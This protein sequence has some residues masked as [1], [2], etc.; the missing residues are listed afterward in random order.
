MPSSSLNHP[1][2][3]KPFLT[4]LIGLST[5]SPNFTLCSSTALPP[6]ELNVIWYVW[7]ATSSD[8]HLAYSVTSLESSCSKSEATVNGL[9][10][11]L[12]SQYQPANTWSSFS[13]SSG[14][15]IDVTPN[16]ILSSSVPPL[17]SK[18]IVMFVSSTHEA[19]RLITKTKNIN[20]AIF[21]FI[22][23]TPILLLQNL[24][25]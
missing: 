19:N 12:L 24:Y 25:F 7:F 10:N 11:E 9:W 1:T 3:I 14:I 5:S 20:T 18:F 2:K 17:L 6:R 21:F 23:I 16:S 8:T 4:G 13:G 15:W 22:I